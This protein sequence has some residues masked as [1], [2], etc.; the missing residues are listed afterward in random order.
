MTLTVLLWPVAALI[1]KRCGHVLLPDSGSR[2][3]FVLSR[4]ACLLWLGMIATL[5]IPL[6]RVDE[7]IS[8]LGNKIDPWLFASHAFGWL[9]AASVPVL[10]LTAYAFLADVRHRLVDAPA[11]DAPDVRR[12]H[13]SLLRLA[14][15]HALSGTQVL[16][17]AS[18]QFLCAT[19]AR[20]S[21]SWPAA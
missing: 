17:S 9:A 15:A 10:I 19:F 14:M 18:Q 11:C 20:V 16:R 8:F 21:V 6:A 7:D 3:L 1:R 12:N 4:I 2:V 5:A 13:L